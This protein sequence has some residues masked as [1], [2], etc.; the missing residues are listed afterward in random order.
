MFSGEGE[1]TAANVDL[2]L[3][4]RFGLGASGV[5]ITPGLHLGTFLSLSDECTSTSVAGADCSDEIESELGVYVLLGV[6][7]GFSF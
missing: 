5:S 6:T 7:L 4:G 1:S 3:G 2:E